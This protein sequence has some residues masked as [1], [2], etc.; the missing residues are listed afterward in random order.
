M[1]WPI[2]AKSI[3]K[4]PPMTEIEVLNRDIKAL[5]EL[6]NIA[7][8]DLANRSFTPYEFREKR[9]E[10]DRCAA[11]LRRH[12]QALEVERHRPR[13]REPVQDTSDARAIRF[14]LLDGA[15]EIGPLAGF[16]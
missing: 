11:E 3:S 7:W 13:P 16:G 6:L 1:A 5:K 14:R 15:T 9:N 12:L 4:E 10:M 2:S 8:R